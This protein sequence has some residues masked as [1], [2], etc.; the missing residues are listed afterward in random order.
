MP[1]AIDKG[2]GNSFSGSNI[3]FPFL[4]QV[5]FSLPNAFEKACSGTAMI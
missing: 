4:K 5:A 2:D 1:A 3:I